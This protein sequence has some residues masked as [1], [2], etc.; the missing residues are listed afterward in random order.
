MAPLL[1]APADCGNKCNQFETPISMGKYTR[2]MTKFIFVVEGEGDRVCC[3]AKLNNRL[4]G[5]KET[6][7]MTQSC[8]V[9]SLLGV[10]TITSTQARKMSCS[11]PD[12]VL[13]IYPLEKK[14]DFPMP[15]IDKYYPE[16]T[17]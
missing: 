6:H 16:L 14:K 2:K 17:E 5:F 13:A 3:E 12:G 7:K 1:S 15:F 8:P 4:P 11:M 9:W 10:D